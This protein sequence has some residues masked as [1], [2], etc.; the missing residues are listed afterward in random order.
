MKNAK[1]KKEGINTVRRDRRTMALCYTYTLEGNW[2]KT[3]KLK[4]LNTN[5]NGQNLIAYVQEKPEIES[6]KKEKEE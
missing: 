2:A 3:S 6:E 1:P 4:N 5:Q